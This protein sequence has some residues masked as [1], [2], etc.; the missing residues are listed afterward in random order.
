MQCGTVETDQELQG[1]VGASELA[2]VIP[3]PTSWA[4]GLR[5]SVY[6]SESA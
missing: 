2:R 4:L 3:L 5:H 1:E 6:L